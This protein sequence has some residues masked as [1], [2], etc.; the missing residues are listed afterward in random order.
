MTGSLLKGHQNLQRNAHIL[1]VS[2]LPMQG[3]Y[4]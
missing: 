4:E 1:A 2:N 3:E